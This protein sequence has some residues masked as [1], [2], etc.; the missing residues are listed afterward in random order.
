MDVPSQTA[1]HDN[2]GVVHGIFLLDFNFEV[3]DFS[4]Q[5][6]QFKGEILFSAQS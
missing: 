5:P 1:T 4:V 2:V 3:H 6:F